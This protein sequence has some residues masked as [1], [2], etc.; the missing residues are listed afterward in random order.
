MKTFMQ[1][2]ERLQLRVMEASVVEAEHKAERARL[3]VEKAR[4]EL[5]T[6]QRIDEHIERSAGIT[7]LPKLG[8]AGKA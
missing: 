8:G 3:E 1:E 5:R 4:V 7:E 2:L 6:A